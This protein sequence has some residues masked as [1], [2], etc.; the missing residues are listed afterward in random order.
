MSTA[1]LTK[2]DD[3]S[4]KFLLKGQYQP[5]REDIML[6][7][8]RFQNIK[9]SI[10]ENLLL[11][12][13]IN[14]KVTGENIPLAVLVTEM[15]VKGIENLVDQGALRFTHWTPMML[16]F[17]D[18]TPGLLPLI[19]GRHN[20]KAHTDPEESIALGLNTLVQKPNKEDRRN[21]IRKIRD[22]YDYAEKDIEHDAKDRTLS[23]FNSNKLLGLGLNKD[24]HDLY[25]LPTNLK[26]N[27]S[28]C[29]SDLLE[30]KYITQAKLTSTDSVSSHILLNDCI[31]KTTNI[32][33]P[34]ALA[35]II[36]MENFPDLQK[37]YSH[38]ETPLK[39]AVKIRNNRNIRKF[40]TWLDEAIDGREIS[41]F[42]ETYINAI[43]NKKGFF[44]SNIGR[45][46][47][48]ATMALAGAGV[49]AI[50]GPVGATIGGAA[51]PLLTPAAEFGLDLVDEYFLNNLIQGWSPRMFIDELKKLNIK[52][53]PSIS[54]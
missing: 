28:K 1:Y 39:Q 19:S 16:H 18:N 21:L 51:G 30:Y 13:K 36:E 34:D 47:K 27:L 32:K 20:S 23:A 12:D 10:F 2:L 11:F 43:A 9:A 50:A 48:V 44:D 35:K 24:H 37:I 22:L 40:R 54:Y 14:L 45:F 31:N 46:T 38:I 4:H 25:Q 3:F 53:E 15:G 42:S 17:V 5:T 52:I 8:Q 26:T 7:Q 33:H 41:D 6:F 29:A 49:G